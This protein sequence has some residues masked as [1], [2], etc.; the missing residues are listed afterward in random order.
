MSV[1][2][3]LSNA[4]AQRIKLTAAGDCNN[5]ALINVRSL[6][7]NPG[8]V[9]S[10]AGGSLTLP[11][12]I[13]DTP[14]ADYALTYNSVTGVVGKGALG[15]GGGGSVNL[16]TGVS[17][18][19][20]TANGGTGLSTV[21]SNDQVLTIAGGV[22]TW[23]SKT[24]IAAQNAG[25][26]H[27]FNIGKLIY[28]AS[29]TTT[30]APSA[31]IIGNSAT[32]AANTNNVVIG[33][34]ATVTGS[35]GIRIGDSG[36]SGADAIA[37]GHAGIA[38][39]RSSV[40][41]STANTTSADSTLL[42]FGAFSTQDFSVGIGSSVVINGEGG[43]A[44]GYGANTDHTDGI[45]LGHD[46]STAAANQTI[47]GSNLVLSDTTQYGLFTY[48]GAHPLAAVTAPTDVLVYKSSSGQIGRPAV[49]PGTVGQVLTYNGTNVVWNSSWLAHQNANDFKLFNVRDVIYADTVSGTNPVDILIGSD[50]TSSTRRTKIGHTDLAT[51][52]S[53][54]GTFNGT[55]VVG[56]NSGYTTD[57]TDNLTSVNNSCILGNSN[58]VYGPNSVAIGFAASTGNSFLPGVNQS[59]IAI[60]SNI[61]AKGIN[62]IS[63]GS[64]SE[65]TLNDSLS[66][67]YD[68]HARATKGIAIGTT[69]TNISDKSLVIGSNSRADN[70]NGFSGTIESQI[71]LGTN[72]AG[73]RDASIVIGKNAT[74][75]SDFM[76]SPS[77]CDNAI[78]LGT[79]TRALQA[80]VI[81]LGN[82][83]GPSTQVADAAYL[84]TTLALPA[85]GSSSKLLV[86]NTSNGQWG[87]LAS[88]TNGYVLS[89]QSGGLVWKPASAVP[90]G[91][92]LQRSRVASKTYVAVN[93]VYDHN[94][95]SNPSNSAPLNS[96][97]GSGT[98]SLL[99]ST[100]ITPT[101]IGNIIY[102]RVRVPFHAAINTL[103]SIG[104]FDKST[105]APTFTTA[106]AM[107]WVDPGPS[108][109]DIVEFDYQYTT[110]ALTQRIYEVHA[111]TQSTT[112]VDVPTARFNSGVNN[113]TFFGNL[114]DYSM[115]I[116]EI[117][118]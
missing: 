35:K 76:G 73:Y 32:T 41:G 51:L 55:I 3:G 21:G 117:A 1:T 58:F 64:G 52:Y 63:I 89:Q 14:S 96:S 40:F 17:G 28:D 56:N 42:G 100:T 39:A 27:L 29:A 103:V 57:P 95:G 66:I 91:N 88:G 113:D 8:Y 25:T 59:A 92:T 2:Y 60:G 44:I 79:S 114:M 50:V 102:I 70:N 87:P 74:T 112:V 110:T 18:V 34:G 80:N 23:A 7:L 43:I 118:Q 81:A 86:Y 47:I 20:A 69:N 12:N 75:N 53:G 93:K 15:G 13:A 45:V 85:I 116:E 77:G 107:G 106:V 19:L 36:T 9:I 94:S 115:M 10:T 5:Q 16:A 26:Q 111:W 84:P 54:V 105:L 38:G 11:R 24:W 82:S 97:F 71:V 61:Q 68:V 67:G 49:A 4:V 33:H 72:A 99:L 101:V 78:A 109:N 65:S 108:G 104:L 48:S 37:I 31:I 90:A 62:A 46:S 83:A 98:N 30:V 22:P 6:E